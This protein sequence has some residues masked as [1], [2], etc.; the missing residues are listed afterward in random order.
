MRI[1][2][3]LEVLETSLARII[4]V[5]LGCDPVFDITEIDAASNNKV[6]DMRN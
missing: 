1:F 6:D 3:A 4:A 5:E 2:Q